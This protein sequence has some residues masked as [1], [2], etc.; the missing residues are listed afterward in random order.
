M[1]ESPPRT[2]GPTGQA[3]AP[4]AGL[5]SSAFTNL[6]QALRGLHN[7]RALTAMLGCLVAGTLI[8]GVCSVL[9]TRL[10]A[11][12]GLL[13]G[14]ALLVAVATGVN[15]AGML[16]MDQARGRP[17]RALGGAV[18]GGLACVPR[19]IAL[20]LGLWLIA[21]AVFLAIALAY[22]VC[23][24]PYLGP[25]LFV[26]VFPLSVLVAGGTVCG[27]LLCM[28]LS[29]PA[30]WE[31]QRVIGAIAQSVAIARTRGVEALLLCAVGG[32]LS[33]AVGMV[34]FGVLATGLMPTLGLSA[35]LLGG[36]G[37]AGATAI[38]QGG[39]EFGGGRALAGAGGSHAA[40]AVIGGGL[41]WS[42]AVSLVGMVNLLGLNLVYLRLTEGLG[43]AGA[44]AGPSVNAPVSTATPVWPRG[45]SQPAGATVPSAV[46]SSTCPQCL[47]AVG[48]E[49]L[50]CGLCGHRLK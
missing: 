20:G 31:G 36:E 22:F 40:A 14:L 10:G 16:L 28:A 7:T 8:A 23:K 47:S 48:T 32:V 18:R 5:P 13:G 34:V 9:A 1:I 12:L 33:A 43:T 6:L 35:A 24:F 44:V 27:L 38:A 17:A 45:R 46:K 15:A 4:L 25:L 11:A 29:L 19:V 41:L 26:A 3:S 30:L 49:D 2:A 21:V 37:F 50:F 39:T 42:L